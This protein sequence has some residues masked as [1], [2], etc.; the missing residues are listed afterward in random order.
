[1]TGAPRAVVL[2]RVLCSAGTASKL[3]VEAECAREREEPILHLSHGLNGV[4]SQAP[5]EPR[6]FPSVLRWALEQRN[7]RTWTRDRDGCAFGA[8][9]RG[10]NSL[11]G[12]AGGRSMFPNFSLH[13]Y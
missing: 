3:G 11:S 9:Q 12:R 4:A 13:T 7:S 2:L 8:A 10:S 6:W 1:M 5:P